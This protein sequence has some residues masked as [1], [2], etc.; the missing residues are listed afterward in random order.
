MRRRDR[1]LA[2]T[3]LLADTD[4][5]V[6]SRFLVLIQEETPEHFKGQVREGGEYGKMRILPRPRWRRV[7]PEEP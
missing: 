1:G 6:S 4:V 3:A 2:F 5:A 7:L